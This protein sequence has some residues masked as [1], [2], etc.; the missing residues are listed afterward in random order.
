[1]P[2]DIRGMAPLLQVFDM[3]TALHFYRDI[4]GFQVQ[5]ASTPGDDCGWALLKFGGVELMLNTAYD[6]GQRPKAP[7]LKRIAA[8][9]DT[10]LFFG[11]ED[12][13]GT[14][15]HL[16]AHGI[17]VRPPKVAPYGMR[18]LYAK[19]PDGFGL[20]FQW[21]ATQETHDAWV[22]AYGIEPKTIG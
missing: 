17:S 13:D 14:Y 16:L 22:K 18:Q 20:C 9:D 8:H 7:D 19:D 6:E 12:I 10:G 3:P 11:C 15:Q 4:L 21:P 1:M 2:V 5:A